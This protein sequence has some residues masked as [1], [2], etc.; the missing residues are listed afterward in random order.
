MRL[1]VANGPNVRGLHSF[2][3]QLILSYS[4]HHVTQLNSHMCP[5]VAQV[6]LRRERV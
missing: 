6:E 2:R 3:F 4:V 1:A 5:G